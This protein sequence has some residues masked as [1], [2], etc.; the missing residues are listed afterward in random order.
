MTK[1]EFVKLKKGD[2]LL[3]MRHLLNNDGQI[4]VAENSEWRVRQIEIRPLKNQLEKN[5]RLVHLFND[6]NQQSLTIS[7]DNSVNFVVYK[8]KRGPLP[9]E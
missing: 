3:V 7:K 8:R 9:Q 5:E 1:R 2:I 6:Q 4:L